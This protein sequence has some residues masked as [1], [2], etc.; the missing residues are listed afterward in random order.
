[1]KN[2]LHCG[3]IGDGPEGSSERL[4]SSPLLATKWFCI[5][6]GNSQSSSTPSQLTSSSQ[7]ADSPT[8]NAG[9]GSNVQILDGGAIP[10]LKDVALSALS[11]SQDQTQQVFNTIDDALAATQQAAQQSTAAANTLLQQQLA[12]QST[13]AANVQSGGQTEQD[14]VIIELAAIGAGLLFLFLYFTRK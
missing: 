13:L 6:S 8:I 4:I 1:V 11:G 7:G 10:A 12:S 14:K 5:G 9:G 2:I 3:H